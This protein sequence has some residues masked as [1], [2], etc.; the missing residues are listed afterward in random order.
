MEALTEDLF[1]IQLKSYKEERTIMFKDSFL[2]L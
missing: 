2:D 1:N